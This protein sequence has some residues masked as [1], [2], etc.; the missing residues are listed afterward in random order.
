MKSLVLLVFIALAG[1]ACVT[2][3]GDV[4]VNYPTVFK[5]TTVLRN[6]KTFTVQPGVYKA[7]LGMNAK[8][9]AVLSLDG[10]RF[11]ITLNVPR[12][13]DQNGITVFMREE[14]GQPYN[15]QFAIESEL[16][17]GVEQRNITSCTVNKKVSECE[18]VNGRRLC[19]VVSKSFEG[20]KK[21]IFKMDH[22][23]RT[24]FVTLWDPDTHMVHMTFQGNDRKSVKRVLYE[25]ACH[26]T[27]VMKIKKI[28]Y[29]DY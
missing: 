21:V 18:I 19:E 2:P 3:E 4:T 16:S 14:V 8:K 11:G 5:R 27:E 7:K 15:I 20:K 23:D 10:V 6:T 9:K 1:T 25:S 28:P 26:V 17:E 24:F 12:S 22:T 29:G 13:I